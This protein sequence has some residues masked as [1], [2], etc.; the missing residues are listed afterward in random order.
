M[1]LQQTGEEF[2]TQMKILHA[3]AEANLAQKNILL[4]KITSRFGNNLKGKHFAL[5]GLA[6]KPD[7]DDL[8]NAPSLTVLEGLSKQG[9]SVTAHD[10]VAM[11]EPCAFLVTVTICAMPIHP[12]RHCLMPMH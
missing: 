6:F 1:A 11:N 7:T 5:W 9:A 10:P 8:R 2:G 12:W 3:V 4:K